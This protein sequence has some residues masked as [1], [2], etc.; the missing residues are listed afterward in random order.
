VPP[1]SPPF[2]LCLPGKPGGSDTPLDVVNPD[3]SSTGGQIWLAADADFNR[4]PDE[5]GAA[6]G[7]MR[8]L[9]TY[10]LAATLARSASRLTERRDEAARTLAAEAG[11]RE[12]PV[13]TIEEMTEPGLL[14]INRTFS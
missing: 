8:N 2:P 4:A 6:A 12:G 10:R 13:Y 3:D 11:S 7:R 5:A 1:S 9:A 14:V